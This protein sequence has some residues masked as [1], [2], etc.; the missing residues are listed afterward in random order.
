ML[1]VA[2]VVVSLLLIEILTTYFYSQDGVGDFLT[3]ILNI[4]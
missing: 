3:I 4:C 1:M 2:R